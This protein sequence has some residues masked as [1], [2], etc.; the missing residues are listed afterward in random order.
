MTRCVTYSFL[1]LFCAACSKS[2]PPSTSN[3]T[4]PSAAGLS[5][6]SGIEN[7]RA[8]LSGDQV[9]LP[10]PIATLAQGQAI[11]QL[12]PGGTE[13]SYR[14]IASNIDNIVGAHLHLAAAGA[15]GPLVALLLAPPPPPGGGRSDGVLVEGT[16]TASMLFGPLTGQPLSALIDAIHAG[17][18]YV[19]VPTN[20]GAAPVNSGPGDYP[21]GELRGQV[22]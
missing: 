20:D 4:A 18:V 14:V 15:R 3:P 12:R 7:F 11:F 10:L 16:L 2:T 6:A 9:V 8:H 13:L 22:E 1:L 5:S 17:N 19:D 21:G